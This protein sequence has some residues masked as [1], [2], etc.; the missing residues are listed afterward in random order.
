MMVN[1]PI[2]RCLLHISYDLLNEA[3]VVGG[4]GEIYMMNQ[5][6]GLS[7]ELKLEAKRWT[8][9]DQGSLTNLGQ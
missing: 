6:V 3:Y 7:D 4:F 1:S 2:V 5:Q 8:E 9:K